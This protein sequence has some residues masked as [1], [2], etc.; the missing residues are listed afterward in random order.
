MEP[1]RADRK[2]PAHEDDGAL[3]SA[4][5]DEGAL[6]LHGFA[7]HCAKPGGSRHR[8]EGPD[9]LPFAMPELQ[10]RLVRDALAGQGIEAE[11]F[12]PEGA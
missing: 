5:G 10:A 2:H 6:V 9:R 3:G 1:A 12:D 7:A 11:L 4:G 8:F